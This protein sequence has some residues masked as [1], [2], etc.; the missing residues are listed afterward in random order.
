MNPIAFIDLETTGL[1]AARHE[2]LEIGVVVAFPGTLAERDRFEVRVRPERIED[3]DPA[4]LRVNGWSPEAWADAVPLDVALGQLAPV[5]WGTILAGHNVA[6]D[7]AFLDAAWRAA[8]VSPPE[9]DHHTLDT[10][11]LAWPL[12]EAGEVDSL[13]LGAVCA[14]LGIDLGPGHRALIDARRSLAVARRLL[15]EAREFAKR[16]VRGEREGCRCQGSACSRSCGAS[17][18]SSWRCGDGRA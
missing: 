2:I 5:L 7:R 4:A 9:Q 17:G 6:F 12:L 14:A 3:A 15:P 11:V 1:D 16:A 18:S 10:A 8:G 13:S